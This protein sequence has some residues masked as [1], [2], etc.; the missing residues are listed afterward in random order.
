MAYKFN[1]DFSDY[2]WPYNTRY[3]DLVRKSLKNPWS[4]SNDDAKLLT[5]TAKHFI[6][7]NVS[8]DSYVYIVGCEGLLCTNKDKTPIKIGVTSQKNLSKRIKQLQVGNPLEIVEL[9]RSK[10]TNRRSA[11]ALEKVLHSKFKEYNLRGEWFLVN[12]D[13]VID[14]LIKNQPLADR[15]EYKELALEGLHKDIKLNRR[16]IYHKARTACVEA[17]D[18]LEKRIVNASI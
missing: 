8:T 15:C 9:Y 14:S 13:T 4:I 11:E 2:Y 5:E 10:N 1:V 6:Q 16:G 18:K 17:L 12:T 3:V 7:S